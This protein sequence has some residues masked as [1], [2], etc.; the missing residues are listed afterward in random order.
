VSH[1]EVHLNPE[2]LEQYFKAGVPAVVAIS[3]SVGAKLEIDP[4]SQL[5]R[6][7][8]PAQGAEPEVTSYER[9][10]VERSLAGG[11]PEKFILT[12]DASDI[13]YEAYSFLEAVLDYVRAGASL[14]KAVSDALAGQAELLAKRSKLTDE[15]VTGLWGELD[16][17]EHLV[18]RMGEVSA[19]EAWL[20]PLAQEHDF[21]F[22]TFEA[23]VKT[24]TANTRRHVIGS[25]TQLQPSP[26]RPLYLVSIQVTLGGAGQDALTLPEKV[27]KVRDLLEKTRRTFETHLLGL[28]Y[29]SED[30][31]LYRA[32]Y[33]LRSVPRAYLVDDL[34]PAITQPRLDGVVPQ[35]GL[36][37]DVSYRVDVTGLT[38]ALATFPL[39]SY[40]E[41][42]IHYD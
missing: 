34:F 21:A 22:P 25:A 3:P 19:M 29:H 42:P 37:S 11:A 39:H 6:L 36:V 4:H 18:P 16:V 27:I 1:D 20:G 8:I 17:F 33:Q 7:V 9:L 28:G 14:R 35:P 5:L 30:A 41:D 24:T 15:R 12:V 32:S 38:H 10:T 2:T 26:E 40:T 31:D 23:E 13:H